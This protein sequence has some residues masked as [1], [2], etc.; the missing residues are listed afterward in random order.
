VKMAIFSD[1]HGNWAAAVRSLD[2][3]GDFDWVV[4]LGDTTDDA[5][6]TELALGRKLLIVSGNCD[7]GGKYP[8]SLTL[9]M[10]GKRIFI[11]HG[12]RFHVKAGLGEL[13][14]KALQEGA[15]IVLYGHTHIASVEELNGILF[16]NPGAMKLSMESLTMGILQIDEGIASVEI[17]DVDLLLNP[18]VD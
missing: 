6:F 11:C 16:I 4:H 3:S 18:T 5:E 10:A 12:D 8:R 2:L 1:T 15:D 13:Y 17:S 7:G 14:K 9:E